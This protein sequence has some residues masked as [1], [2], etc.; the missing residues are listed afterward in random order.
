MASLFI[1]CSN[2]AAIF[3]LKYVSLELACS[4]AP[5]PMPGRSLQTVARP[6]QPPVVDDTLLVLPGG[7]AGRDTLLVLLRRSGER[8]LPGELLLQ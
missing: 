4:A 5:R 6:W 3:G 2:V 8:V 1:S 7:E